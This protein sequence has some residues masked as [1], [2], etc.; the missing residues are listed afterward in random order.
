MINTKKEYLSRHTTEY[1]KNLFNLSK[2]RHGKIKKKKIKVVS[3]DVENEFI[4]IVTD[5]QISNKAKIEFNSFELQEFL[6]T[7][8]H[9][10]GKR[11]NKG[12]YTKKE[13]VI[14]PSC[15]RDETVIKMTSHHL[16]PQQEGGKNVP[17]NYMVLCDDCHCQ[18]HL[19]YDNTFLAK[20][21]NT[22]ESILCDSEMKK[23]V[24]FII[25]NKKKKIKK[26]VK[27]EDDEKKSFILFIKVTKR[28]F[29]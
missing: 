21:R 23:A 19:I 15:K 5:H 7:R 26:K 16:I 28:L 29:R 6:N 3:T 22:P 27:I 25:K 8:E 20:N 1:I 13:S 24:R 11:T 9:I 17:E 2:G 18:L 12:F 14:C 4:V 10:Q